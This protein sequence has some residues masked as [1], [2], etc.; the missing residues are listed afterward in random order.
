MSST[1]LPPTSSPLVIPFPPAVTSS[2]LQ[3]SPC[4]TMRSPHRGWHRVPPDMQGGNA[5]QQDHNASFVL[6]LQACSTL[7]MLFAELPLEGES[8]R[9]AGGWH[10]RGAHGTRQAS[11]PINKLGYLVFLQQVS[12]KEEKHL[13][14]WNRQCK[15]WGGEGEEELPPSLKAPALGGTLAA[16]E[17]GEGG[18]RKEW[19]RLGYPALQ[20]EPLSPVEQ[21]LPGEEKRSVAQLGST[22][23][24]GPYPVLSATHQHS[25]PLF[26]PSLH[27]FN[28]SWAPF[29]HLET[30]LA[31]RRKKKSTGSFL[32]QA[33]AGSQKPAR[34]LWCSLDRLRRQITDV[35]KTIRHPSPISLTFLDTQ[36]TAGEDLWAD[37]QEDFGRAPQPAPKI[38]NHE[39]IQE[40]VT[41]LHNASAVPSVPLL[42][43]RAIQAALPVKNLSCSQASEQQ[44]PASLVCCLEEKLLS[45][46]E[47]NLYLGNMLSRVP[48]HTLTQALSS[49]FGSWTPKS[50]WL[51]SS[52]EHLKPI[53]RKT[54]ELGRSKHQEDLDFCWRQLQITFLE[55]SVVTST[56]MALPRALPA[57]GEDEEVEIPG[58]TWIR[59]LQHDG[60]PATSVQFEL[61]MTWKPRDQQ[62][63][64]YS[65]KSF[66]S[67]QALFNVPFV[68][69]T[70]NPPC[71]HS[72]SRTGWSRSLQ[73]VCQPLSLC[74]TAPP[75]CLPMGGASSVSATKRTAE[76]LVACQSLL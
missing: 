62:F 61:S 8:G 73:K 66:K 41:C 35:A 1:G 42:A 28:N 36:G 19:S 76:N 27:H 44:L 2:H 57:L 56:R 39:A 30:C 33:A 38:L 46:Q 29:A 45:F 67:P 31:E 68:A 48:L 13:G 74:P 11:G 70:Y 14:P 53:E 23:G 75:V 34:S 15:P 6:L 50:S 69:P 16:P 17:M 21:P 4:Y 24:G 58:E 5:L 37:R 22:G 3:S 72:R 25:F 54:G 12:A 7:E 43:C 49:S 52:V 65:Q 26:P 32:A 64:W 40:T 10:P 20:P 55:H 18:G 63:L 59:H 51:P 60:S 47:S 9:A 71:R